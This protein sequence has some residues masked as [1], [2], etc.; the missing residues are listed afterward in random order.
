MKSLV[1]IILLILINSCVENQLK[2]TKVGFDNQAYN[3]DNYQNSNSNDDDYILQHE[4]Y[5]FVQLLEA[6]E[7]ITSFLEVRFNFYKE[8]NIRI[9]IHG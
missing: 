7:I 1:S 5:R 6:M 2:K 9:V 4:K 8:V 3:L